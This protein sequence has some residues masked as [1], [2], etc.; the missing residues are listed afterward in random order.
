MVRRCF[1]TQCHLLCCSGGL[2]WCSTTQTILVSNLLDGVDLY[3]LKDRPYFERRML[4]PRIRCNFP[5]QVGFAR[6]GQLAISG[7]DKGE[8]YVWDR[9]L[10]DF[11]QVLRHGGNAFS[12]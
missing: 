8:V 6:Y 3:C 11:Y 10:G 12:I 4:V 2:A 7:S 5:Q 1:L 9:D